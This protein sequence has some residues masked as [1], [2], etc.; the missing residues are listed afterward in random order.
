VILARIAHLLDR[1]NRWVGEAVAWLTLF[2]VVLVCAVV[3]LRYV[4]D[5]GAIWLQESVTWMHAMVFLLGAAYT[6]GQDEHVRVDIFYR[7]LGARGQ[8]WVDLGGTVLLLLPVC[9]YIFWSSLDYVGA[10][11]AV[12][13]ASRETGGLPGLY[14]LKT[15]IPLTALLLAFQ[16]IV[17]IIRAIRRIVGGDECPG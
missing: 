2:M 9:L 12:R 6:L 8:G 4:F 15:V 16:G 13:E 5:T 10:A 11:W 17:V 14:V 1:T 3:L 7:G